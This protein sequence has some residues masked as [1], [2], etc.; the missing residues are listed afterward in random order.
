MIK[1][2]STTRPR[3]EQKVTRGKSDDECWGW[4]GSVSRGGYGTLW[5]GYKNVYIHRLAYSMFLG[6]IG[7]SDVCHRCDNPICSNPQ[8]LFLGTHRE[9]MQDSIN[10][11]RQGFQK[12]GAVELFKKH[13]WVPKGENH[14]L[15]KMSVAKVR[16]LRRLASTQTTKQLMDKFEISKSTVYRIKNGTLWPNEEGRERMAKAIKVEL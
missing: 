1:I 7:S 15:A 14:G 10:K 13:R 16:E 9:N 11:G 5:T 2:N 6:A 8:H 3:F 4:T 12:P